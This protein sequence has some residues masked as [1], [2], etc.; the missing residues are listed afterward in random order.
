MESL[1]R[2][3]HVFDRRQAELSYWTGLTAGQVYR[4]LL[5]LQG[6]GAIVLLRQ[7]GGRSPSVFRLSWLD[8]E[9]GWGGGQPSA[10][11]ADSDLPGQQK[12]PSRP[13]KNGGSQRALTAGAPPSKSRGSPAP[14][15]GQPRAGEGPTINGKGLEQTEGEKMAPAPHSASAASTE[16]PAT[17]A[18]SPEPT[19][20]TAEHHVE[21]ALAIL[22]P[23]GASPKL[24]GAI[25][26]ALA[27]AQAAGVSAEHV[28]AALPR[29]GS[30]RPW[31]RIGHAAAM[32]LEDRR[33]QAQPPASTT[34]PDR[35]FA[36]RLRHFGI[37]WARSDSLDL[38]GCVS[39]EGRVLV[40]LGGGRQHYISPLDEA[41][42]T[43]VDA[44]PAGMEAQNP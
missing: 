16:Q 40:N 2:Y 11:A 17:V 29:T 9:D 15:K 38:E 3:T 21:A 41:A 1:G 10:P 8:A 22:A 4:V 43:F 6:I 28:T 19:L 13:F 20:A 12:A 26:N 34:H 31:E 32:V 5:S 44:K 35:A 14:V 42:W 30:G 37:V 7:G 39:L 33:R 18:A 27:D 23:G 36:D 25:L 24:R